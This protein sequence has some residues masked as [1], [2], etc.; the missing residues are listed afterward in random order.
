MKKI[1]SLKLK[2][3][4]QLDKDTSIRYTL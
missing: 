3:K 1:P 2:A 4:S